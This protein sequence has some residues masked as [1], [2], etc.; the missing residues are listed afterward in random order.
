ML[1]A[2]IFVATLM[3]PS[4]QQVFRRPL[5]PVVA[6][7]TFRYYVLNGQIFTESSNNRAYVINGRIFR[8]TL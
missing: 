4:S 8:E 1:T 7:E 5:Y 6:G 3:A 2:M